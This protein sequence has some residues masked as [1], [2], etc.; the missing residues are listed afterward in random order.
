MEPGATVIDIAPERCRWQRS[1]LEANHLRYLS[2]RNAS[3]CQCESFA[4]Y[5]SDSPPFDGADVRPVIEIIRQGMS[6]S[7]RNSTLNDQL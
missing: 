3:R 1:F 4:C 2:I 6:Q 7:A 5:P